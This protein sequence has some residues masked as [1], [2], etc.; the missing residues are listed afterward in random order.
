MNRPIEFRAWD[1]NANKMYED[2]LLGNNLIIYGIDPQNKDYDWDYLDRYVEIMQFTDHLDK[3]GKK[4]FKGDLVNWFGHILGIDFH[5]GRFVARYDGGNAEICED[6]QGEECEVIGN[7]FENP[8]LL[9]L[10][11]DNA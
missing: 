10:K 3:N 4:I 7:I 11:Q 8:E 5:N 1:K 6:W 2:V 9:S